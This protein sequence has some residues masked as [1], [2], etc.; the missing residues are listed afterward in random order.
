M[1]CQ[2]C[3]QGRISVSELVTISE[4][5]QTAAFEALTQRL[6]K[7]VPDTIGKYPLAIVAHR[8]AS[9]PCINVFTPI[10]CSLGCRRVGSDLPLSRCSM[11]DFSS[12]RL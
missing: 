6:L 4:H 8:P 1:S 12:L 11:S 10:G 2:A 7:N 3:K 5:Y 9:L